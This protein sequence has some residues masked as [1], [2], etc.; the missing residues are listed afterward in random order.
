MK[1]QGDDLARSRGDDKMELSGGSR[2]AALAGRRGMDGERVHAAG[3]LGPRA[4]R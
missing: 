2:N 4:F 1:F 3:Q